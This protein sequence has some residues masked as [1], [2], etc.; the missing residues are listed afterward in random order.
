MTRDSVPSPVWVQVV[1][2][3]GRRCECT[4]ACGHPHDRREPEARCEATGTGRVLYAAPRD[5]GVPAEAAWRVPTGELA[6][7]C[8]GCLD[9]ARAASRRFVTGPVCRAD[10]LPLDDGWPEPVPVCRSRSRSRRV[11][12]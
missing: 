1:T 3:A 7:W 8:A 4:G 6:A 12:A 10:G 9:G 5:S 11:V 2:A